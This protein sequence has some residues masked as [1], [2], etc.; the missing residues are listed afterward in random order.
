MSNKST[1][2]ARI[3]ADR[4]VFPSQIQYY[5]YL[6]KFARWREADKRRET[7]SETCERVMKWFMKLPR[8]VGMVSDEEETDLYDS[9][10]H[11][12]ATPSL[13]AVQ[14]AGPSLDRCNSGVNNCAAHGISKP[15]DFGV[16]LYLSMQGTG[17]GFSVERHFIDQ[18]PRVE[19][20][21]LDWPGWKIVVE[22]N[23]ISWCNTLVEAIKLFLC[24][25]D[26]TLDVSK[27]RPK[28]SRLKTKGG[29]A[30]GPQPLIDLIDFCRKVIHGAAG[31]RL[32]DLEL[33]DIACMVGE[34]VQVGG[35]RR[36]ALL[37]MSDL[38]S[39]D[40]ASAKTGAWYENNLQRRMANNTA[41]Y[42]G[43]PTK[44]SFDKEWQELVDSHSGERGFFNRDAVRKLMPE[45]RKS[46]WDYE[47][48]HWVTNPCAEITLNPEQ[49]CCLSI[50]VA[51]R[52]DTRESLIRKI[53]MATIWATMQ[54]TADQYEYLPTAWAEITRKERLIGVDITGHADC[55]LLQFDA[56]GREAL[57]EEL[58]AEV[59]A[60]NE[61][62]AKRF[63]INASPAAT[64]VKPSG[65]AGVL[66]NAASGVSARYAAWQ[67][68]RVTE[69]ADSP[70]AE[71]LTA[72]N[73]PWDY[74]DKHKLKKVFAF[75]LKSPDGS[76]TVDQMTAIQQCENCLTWLRHYTEHSVSVSVYVDEHEWDEVR[77]WVWDHFDEIKCMAF[78]P[79]DNGSYKLAPNERMTE[80]QY[81]EMV[82]GFPAIDW[83]RLCEYEKED[84]TVVS[85]TFACYGPGGCESE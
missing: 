62:W 21:Q 8:V 24:G 65:D 60:T 30:S 29:R 57:L 68:R 83:S 15:G 41:A 9:L 72:Q 38:D 84:R 69:S 82:A 43:R 3:A 33:H 50:A 67:M 81:D 47:R 51:R 11:L 45:R 54:V 5:Q 71:M 39:K 31:R 28:G 35:V 85:G 63:G 64:C 56:P 80:G 48:I 22:D 23:T 26:C 16:M 37:S 13:R 36:S 32:T 59:I 27:V 78:F 53:R 42:E 77:E 44:H 34:I 73:V 18:F 58:R 20:R 25:Y 79:K 75:P 70:I 66:F 76:T 49:F 74:T 2:A 40:M 7:W 46:L 1:L 61:K 10:Y 52:T 19:K 55:P 12:E 6:S 17:V 4:K 14:M